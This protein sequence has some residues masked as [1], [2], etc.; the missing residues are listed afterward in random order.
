MPNAGSRTTFAV[1]VTTS[2]YAPEVMQITLPRGISE[3]AIGIESLP[4]SS[5]VELWLLRQDGTPATSGHYFLA[6]SYTAIGLQDLVVVPGNH[7]AQIRA[8][9]GGTSG[10]AIVNGWW[11]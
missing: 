1:P 3:I 8:K 7:A 10:S 6:K 2:N 9:S 5:A 4:T 11:R